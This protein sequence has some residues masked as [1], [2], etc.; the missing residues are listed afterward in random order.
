MRHT[1]ADPIAWPAPVSW[2]VECLVD[3]FGPVLIFGY[4]ARFVK[5]ARRERA[6]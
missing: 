6:E 2:T 1:A 5:S 3:G 4:R